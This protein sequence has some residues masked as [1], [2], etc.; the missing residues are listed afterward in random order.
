V[1]DPSKLVKDIG[2]GI[3]ACV[4]NASACI[5]KAADL[6]KGAAK[7]AGR[8][9]IADKIGKGQDM[10]NKAI[11]V[12]DGV[13]TAYEDGKKSLKELEPPSLL[14]PTATWQARGRPA[15]RLSAIR[16]VL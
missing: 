9:D 13:K 3:K 12:V 14:W 8:A 2:N 1:K 6:A 7:L 11:A 4:S 16:S 5:N 15:S 10:A